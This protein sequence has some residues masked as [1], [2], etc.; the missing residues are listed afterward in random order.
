MCLKHDLIGGFIRAGDYLIGL[1]ELRIKE[2]YEG[3]MV[4]VGLTGP[5]YGERPYIFDNDLWADPDNQVQ[6]I[7][8]TIPT[9]TQNGGDDYYIDNGFHISNLGFHI[10]NIIPPFPDT[11]IK[12]TNPVDLE[13]ALPKFSRIFTG[14]VGLSTILL[15]V[16]FYPHDIQAADQFTIA[17]E[18]FKLPTPL[19]L[20]QIAEEFKTII[21]KLSVQY[22]ERKQELARPVYERIKAIL[23]G[24][25]QSELYNLTDF[26]IKKYIELLDLTLEY[27][28]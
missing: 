8:I 10:S 18:S 1:K 24:L 27:K 28:K 13:N 20:K 5:V 25:F 15:P 2:F 22:D 3:E 11:A 14:L 23:N 21:Y 6:Q 12:F 7:L 19:E 26:H 9:A 4:R 17:V 16:L